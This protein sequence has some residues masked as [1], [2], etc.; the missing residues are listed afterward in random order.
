M[1]YDFNT[2][3]V[4]VATGFAAF[5]IKFVNDGI[6][7]MARLEGGMARHE[8]AIKS[9][10]EEHD[11]AIKSL[12]EE[13]DCA[14]KSLHALQKDT[15]ARH[16][17]EIKSLKDEI[18]S[19]KEEIKSLK[20]D[21]KSLEDNLQ[22]ATNFCEE[23]GKTMATVHREIKEIRR[24]TTDGEVIDIVDRWLTNQI[25]DQNSPLRK[26]SQR[27]KHLYEVVSHPKFVPLRNNAHSLTCRCA[28]CPSE[29]LHPKAV[30]G[31]AHL[32]R[33]EKNKRNAQNHSVDMDEMDSSI[34][35]CVKFVSDLDPSR[36]E[37]WHCCTYS[38]QK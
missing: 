9:L 20:D 5:V 19:L 24:I 36:D 32:F 27:P 7:T 31:V 33:K 10:K 14:I 28:Q 29:H 35:K 34:Q 17:D 25:V 11:C 1:L 18:K 21:I 37:N 8:D 15:N 3:A 30:A 38:W 22:H 26:G 6:K 12:K 13:H 4:L 23:A 16:E 2:Y